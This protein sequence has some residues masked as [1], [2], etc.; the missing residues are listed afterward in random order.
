MDMSRTFSIFSYI[1]K[2]IIYECSQ[3]NEVYKHIYN[4]YKAIMELSD[5]LYNRH[6]IYFGNDYLE[7][8]YTVNIHY[9]EIDFDKGINLYDDRLPLPKRFSDLIE[10]IAVD[11][12][13]E[14]ID[15]ILD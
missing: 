12:R 15:S 7:L 4:D 3:V 8:S 11:I 6:G 5:D 2:C 10:V 14:K 9:S 13:N 1:D